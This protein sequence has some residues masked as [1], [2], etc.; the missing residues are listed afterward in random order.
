M[1]TMFAGSFSVAALGHSVR[2][3]FTSRM[4]VCS[5]L[6]LEF[7]ALGEVP[8]EIPAMK[9]SAVCA[10]CFRQSFAAIIRPHSR[11]YI[12]KYTRIIYTHI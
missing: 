10:A 12:D 2:I 11:S 8:A 9:E 4:Q 1:F 5:S 3:I 7:W 6:A